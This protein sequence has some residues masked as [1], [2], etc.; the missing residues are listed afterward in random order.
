MSFYYISPLEAVPV[1]TTK[2]PW[3]L[4]C[5]HTRHDL[6]D[7]RV[8]FILF[9][10]VLM[11]VLQKSNKHILLH[12]ARLVVMTSVEQYKSGDPSVSCL[13]HEVG[14]RLK[15]LIDSATWDLAKRY[16]TYYVQRKWHNHRPKF[17]RRGHVMNP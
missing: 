15:K 11:H 6:L 9:L 3:I 14:A 5:Q 7:E 17:S 16:T 4:A 10:K 12:Q 1:S 8:E 13:E 2:D